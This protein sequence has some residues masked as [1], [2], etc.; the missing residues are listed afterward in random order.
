VE[1]LVGF[2]VTDEGFVSTSTARKV[3]EGFAAI[4]RKSSRRKA[5]FH[6]RVPAGTNGVTPHNFTGGQAG[7]DYENE[8]IL[9]RGSRFQ[10]TKVVEMGEYRLFYADYLP[11]EGKRKLQV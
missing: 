6:L 10:I 7:N 8:L 2:V 3:S 9:P 11:P 1:N 5:L 4:G